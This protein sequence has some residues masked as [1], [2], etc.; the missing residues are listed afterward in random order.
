MFLERND[1]LKEIQSLNSAK[2]G[3][4]KNIP[5]LKEVVDI[6]SPILTQPWSNKIINKRFFPTNL[7]LANVTLVF[8]KIDPTLAENYR[9][10]SVLPTAS[11]VFEKLMQKQFNNYI[12]KFLSPFLCG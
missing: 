3:T 5:T 12:N 9:P 8:K 6:S 7:K 10:V 1:I 2:N 4:F 11:K